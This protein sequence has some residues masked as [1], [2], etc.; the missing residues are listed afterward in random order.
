MSVNTNARIVI[1]GCGISGVAAAQRLVKAGFHNVR[2]VEAT[3]K[4]GGRIKTGR[5]GEPLCNFHCHL[6]SVSTSLKTHLLV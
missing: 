2:I 1:V 3:A 4:S 5:L 6:Q